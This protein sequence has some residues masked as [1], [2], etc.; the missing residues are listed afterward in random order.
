V[1]SEQLIESAVDGNYV[2]YYSCVLY[3]F[4]PPLL[5]DFIFR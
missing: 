1:A 3:S 5:G 2:T 4:L